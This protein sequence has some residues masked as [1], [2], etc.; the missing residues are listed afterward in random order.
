MDKKEW[1]PKISLTLA[2][3]FFLMFFAWPDWIF[4]N[5]AMFIIFCSFCIVSGVASYILTEQIRKEKEEN[6]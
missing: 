2:I 4:Q 1:I 5:D 6:H 3:I